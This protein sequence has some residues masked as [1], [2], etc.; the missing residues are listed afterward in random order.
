MAV[1][2]EGCV[3]LLDHRVVEFG[4]RVPGDLLIREGQTK[5]PLRKV[6]NR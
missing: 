3:P 1:S 2:L 5:W 4:W 6:L